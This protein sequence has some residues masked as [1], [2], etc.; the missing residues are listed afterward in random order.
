MAVKG[1]DHHRIW[2]PDTAR[3]DGRKPDLERCR[4]K[5]YSR[6]GWGSNQCANRAKVFEEITLK[7]GTVVEMG[8]CKKHCTEHVEGKMEARR[9]QREIQA[10]AEKRARDIRDAKRDIVR[11]VMEIHGLPETDCDGIDFCLKQLMSMAERLKKL[12]DGDA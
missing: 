3:M 4:E 2:A 5:V 6:D 8:F 1:G 12:E 9:R 10:R 11:K 7:D